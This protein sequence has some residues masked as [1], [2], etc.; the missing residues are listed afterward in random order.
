MQ[1]RAL[2][3]ALV[4]APSYACRGEPNAAGS[5]I[6]DAAKTTTVAAVAPPPPP[7]PNPVEELSKAG[8]HGIHVRIERSLEL[9]VTHEIGS[10][11]GSRLSQVINRAL[12]W[13]IRPQS[14]LR[15]GDEID[16][17][18]SLR[19]A[20]EPLVHAIWFKSGKLGKEV[21]AVRY[22]P[23]GQKYG[24]WFEPDGTELE[25]RL[26]GGPIKEY[27]QVTSLIKDGRHHKGVDFKTST[28]TEVSSPWNGTVVRR[29]WG[30]HGNGN[31]VDIQDE[32]SGLNAYFLHLSEIDP[33]M[34][35]GARI[36]VGQR[37]GASGNTGHSTAPHLHYQ[38]VRGSQVLDPFEVHATERIKLP[39]SEVPN[40]EAL[41]QRFLPLRAPHNDAAGDL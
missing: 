13:W 2:F 37:I 24:R 6:V 8:F 20:E 21:H 35:P 9:A 26:V 32:K 3:L 40:L 39:P 41:T 30:G 31:C 27:E 7:P 36:K 22:T 11:E 38:I 5:A 18:Y 28:G 16:A 14:D 33:A 12:I 4:F 29:N 23:V 34:Q 19:G 1:R 17:V 15:P 10:E 25:K